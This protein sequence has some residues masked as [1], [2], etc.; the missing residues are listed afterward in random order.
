MES[1]NLMSQNWEMTLEPHLRWVETMSRAL[2][3]PR[4]CT[5]GEVQEL[6]WPEKQYSIGH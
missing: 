5:V 3:G 1:F 4:V 6:R 2:A